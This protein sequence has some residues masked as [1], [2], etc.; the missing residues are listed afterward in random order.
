MITIPPPRLA[1][2]E[3]PNLPQ[4]WLDEK[5]MLAVLIKDG[6]D[7]CPGKTLLISLVHEIDSTFRDKELKMV[8]S[9]GT[10]AGM[11]G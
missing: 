1:S 8:R 2:E 6:A 9:P 3:T 5:G 11:E 10:E 4:R 7:Y